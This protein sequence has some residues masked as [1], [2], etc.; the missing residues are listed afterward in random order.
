[1][2]CEIIG[3]INYWSSSAK[4]PQ[5]TNYPE[6][7]YYHAFHLRWIFHNNKWKHNNNPDH[8]TTGTIALSAYNNEDDL[9]WVRARYDAI[10]W[11]GCTESHAMAVANCNYFPTLSLFSVLFCLWVLFFVCVFF[12]VFFVFVFVFVF[13]L[14]F[15]TNCLLEKGRFYIQQVSML[16][17]GRFCWYRLTFILAWVRNH[18]ASNVWNEVTYP[19][20]NFND[21]TIEVWELI[22][23][24]IPRF[25][26]DGI[27]YPYWG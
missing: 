8:N 11:V 20:P 10:A 25:I 26:M 22:S 17:Q 13:V 1:M 19:I 15:S 23:N 16:H 2:I 7:I 24:C 18:M 5:E 14:F 3:F 6:Y 9:H 21:V 27:T 4:Q 12:F